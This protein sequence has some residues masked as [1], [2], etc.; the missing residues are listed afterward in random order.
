MCACVCARVCVCV[1][2]RA[3]PKRFL[4]SVPSGHGVQRCVCVYACAR[5]H[6]CVVS[7]CTNVYEWMMWVWR[8][9][10]TCVH[11]WV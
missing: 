9:G 1:C 8:C 7:V 11:V 5:A 4:L 2:V 10:V 3:V 6:L